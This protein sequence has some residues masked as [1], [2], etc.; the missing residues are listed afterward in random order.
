MC[1]DAT[2]EALTIAAALASRSPFLSP[3]E[4]RNEANESKRKFAVLQ[5][6]HLALLAAY[7]QFD[8]TI[9]DAKYSFARERFLGVKTLTAIGSLKRQLLE[10]LSLAGLARSGLQASRIEEG[11]KRAGGNDGVRLALGS[12][13]PPPPDL[14]CAILASALHLAYIV[15][16][17]AT[18]PH[19]S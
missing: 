7:A 19:L 17:G 8:A 2:D 10:T 6:D 1:F 18:G 9:G 16:G 4:R 12:P 15:V 13:S 5:S 11:G 14:L 3:M